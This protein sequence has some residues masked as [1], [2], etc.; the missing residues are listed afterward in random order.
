MTRVLLPL[1]EGFEDLEAVTIIDILRRA[2][3]EMVTAGLQAGPVTGARGTRV[4]PDSQLD[5]VLAQKFDLLVLPGGQPGTRNLQADPRIRKLLLQRQDQGEFVAAICAAPGILAD[6]GLL[7][8]KR[9]TSFPGAIDATRTDLEYREDSVVVDGSIITSRG[10][11][12]AMDFALT[13]VDLLEGPQRRDSVER[14][15]MRPA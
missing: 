3:I 4:L 6:V 11:G 14:S 2:G 12:T 1:A 5:E 8:G 9:A 15:L 10:P 13:L 7:T